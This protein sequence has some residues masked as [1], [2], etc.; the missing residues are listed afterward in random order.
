MHG[1]HSTEA[2]TTRC[3]KNAEAIPAAGRRGKPANTIPT[4]PPPLLAADPNGDPKVLVASK[5]EAGAGA[6]E[7]KG[8]LSKAET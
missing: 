1:V 4:A 3:G 5:P 7:G 8:S 2:T 6:G